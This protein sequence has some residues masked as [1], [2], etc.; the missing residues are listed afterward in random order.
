MCDGESYAIRDEC[1]IWLVGDANSKFDLLSKPSVQI[2]GPISERSD[3]V[4]DADLG[5]S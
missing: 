3:L 4:S 5:R 1:S 2:L